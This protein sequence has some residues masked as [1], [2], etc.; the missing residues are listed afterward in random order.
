MKNTKYNQTNQNQF[1]ELFE[2]NYPYLIEK[3]MEYILKIKTD[4]RNKDLSMIDI[5]MDFSFKNSLDVEL[6][7]DAIRSDSY[8]KSFIEKDCEVHGILKSSI[9]EIE[10]W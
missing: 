10:E 8:L 5:I 6:I 4:E 1:T 9:Q 2:N 7:G 3:L